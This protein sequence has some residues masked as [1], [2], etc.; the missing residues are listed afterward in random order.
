MSEEVKS[1]PMMQRRKILGYLIPLMNL[2]LLVYNGYQTYLHLQEGMVIGSQGFWED[3]I[4]IG[5]TIF[6]LGF[7]PRFFPVYQSKY[8]LGDDGFKITRFM[9]KTIL[10]PYKD[11]DRAEVYVRV[12]KE[13]S[14]EA[15]DYSTDQSAMLRK[16]GLKFIDYTNAEEIIMNIFVEKSIYMVSPEK[17]KALLK[18]F[19]NRNKRFTARIVELTRRG[20]RIQDLS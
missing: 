13:I 19:K 15:T 6:M 20:K 17:P 14:K 18:E 9:R 10:I 12:D 4:L 8:Y 1:L 5:T 2:P 3:M 11:I 7:L 16:S